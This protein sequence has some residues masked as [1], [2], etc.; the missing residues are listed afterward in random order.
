DGTEGKRPSTGGEEG[1]GYREG[2]GAQGNVPDGASVVT[3]RERTLYEMAGQVRL[4]LAQKFAER[5]KAFERKGT[6]EDYKFLWVTDFPFF[7]WDEET[8]AWG[9]A[10]HPFTSPHEDDLKAGRL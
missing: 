10:H 9:A 3:G 7:E 8:K 6:A 1:S 2:G 5:H 4:A